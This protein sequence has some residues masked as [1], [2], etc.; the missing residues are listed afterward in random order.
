MT[1]REIHLEER[2]VPHEKQRQAHTAGERY[3]LYGGAMGGGKSVFL[4]NEAIQLSLDH[5][6]N[7]GLLCLP[8]WTRRKNIRFFSSPFI[9]SIASLFTLHRGYASVTLFQ[10]ASRNRYRLP[11]PCIALPWQ[12]RRFYRMPN[13]KHIESLLRSERTPALCICTPHTKGNQSCR[14]RRFPH[15]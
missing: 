8:A 1:A 14:I 13:L 3:V 10:Q 12:C 2:Y 6:G 7:V 11:L 4:V 9:T 15:H 5:P